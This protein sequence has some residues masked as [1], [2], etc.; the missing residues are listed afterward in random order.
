L[1]FLLW[2]EYS[3]SYQLTQESPQSDV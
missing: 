3:L 2:I 1:I